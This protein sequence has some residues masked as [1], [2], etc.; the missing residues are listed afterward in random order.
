M[1]SLYHFCIQND[2]W[3]IILY[4][5]SKCNTLQTQT[6]WLCH[7]IL[8]STIQLLMAGFS[9]RCRHEAVISCLPYW[10]QHCTESET[11]VCISLC[12]KQSWHFQR[13][14]TIIYHLTLTPRPLTI[15]YRERFCLH[16]HFIKINVRL[17]LHILHCLL[18]N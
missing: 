11:E 18:F 16:L 2:F 4:S 6:L 5:R 14:H 3:C 13:I 1:L 7:L 15:S 10:W 9:R 12:V 17:F 8:W